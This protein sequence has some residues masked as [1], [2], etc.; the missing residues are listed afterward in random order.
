MFLGHV[1]TKEGIKVDPQKVKAIK[2]WSRPTNITEIIS[3]LGLAG[4]YR[5]FV[6][7]FSKVASPMTNLLKKANKFEWTEKCAKASQELRQRLTTAPILTLPMEGKEYTI[8]SDASKNGLGCVMM[9]EDKVVAYASREFKPYEQNYPTHDLELAVVVFALKIWRHYLYGV[10]CKIYTDHQSLKYFFTHKELNLRQ[11]CCLELLKDYDL[12][13][14]Y[15][16]GKANVVAD[17]LSRKAQHS[18][19]TVVITQL[20]LLKGLED[21]GIQLVSHGQ[22]HV[23]LSTLTLQPSI[24]EEI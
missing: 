14:Q 19:N 2:E 13:I 7:E 12:Q 11:R 9:Q 15:H 4:Y 23:Q 5:R 6:K 17:A 1:V 21:L 16:P 20:S 18:S 24:V 8:Y 22:A 10:P 3:F